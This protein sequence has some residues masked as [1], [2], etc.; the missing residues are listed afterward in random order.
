MLERV[1]V[2]SK[3]GLFLAGMGAGAFEYF[4]VLSISEEDMS[5]LIADLCI[6]LTFPFS[7]VAFL[8]AFICYLFLLCICIGSRMARKKG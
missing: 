5:V 6:A 3:G 8:V 4:S 7:F 1:N 2:A